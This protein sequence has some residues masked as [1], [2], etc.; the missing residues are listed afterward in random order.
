MNMIHA[1][2]HTNNKLCPMVEI[3]RKYSNTGKSII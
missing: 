2:S 3:V 1:S